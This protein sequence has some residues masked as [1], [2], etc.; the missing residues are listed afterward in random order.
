MGEAPTTYE[1]TEFRKRLVEL[2]ESEGFELIT[3]ERI[4]LGAGPTI[5]NDYKVIFTWNDYDDAPREDLGFDVR[6]VY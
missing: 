4:I 2:L 3:F 1:L 5:T 6:D